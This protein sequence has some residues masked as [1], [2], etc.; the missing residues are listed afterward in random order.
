MKLVSAV[1][2]TVGSAFQWS[3]IMTLG[4]DDEGVFA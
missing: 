3:A 4:A 2:M 1:A